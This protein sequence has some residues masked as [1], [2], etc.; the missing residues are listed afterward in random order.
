MRVISI[1]L[2]PVF[3]LTACGGAANDGQ[4]APAAIVP[5][6]Q[7]SAAD[8]DIYEE[9]GGEFTLTDQEGR[10][11]QL[12]ETHGKVRLLF[13]GYAMCPDVCPMTLS[14]VVQV[15]RQLAT[16]A[17]ELM[18]LFVSVDP[19]RDTQEKL[20]NYLGYFDL[21]DAAALT[22]TQEEIDSVVDLF[23][24]SYEIESSDSAMGYLINHT[25]YL[26]LLDRRGT[27]RALY[28]PSTK[29][30]EIVVAVRTLL[31]EKA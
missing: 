4:E 1:L 8:L 22:G 13:F 31:K 29:A 27:V 19:E 21:G 7:P 5:E 25:P 12:A 23:K 3:L 30:E 2:L 20:R 16:D 28:R 6:K 14:K 15:R 24:A 17:D 11:F 26:F 9:I 10:P 18:T